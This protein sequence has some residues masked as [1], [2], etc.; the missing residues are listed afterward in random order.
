[1]TARPRQATSATVRAHWDERA[2]SYDREADRIERFLIGDGRDWVCSQ[3][4]GRTLEVAVGT[5]RNLGRY[6]P[7][8]ELVGIDL[9]PGMLAVAR[10][11]ADELGVRVDLREADAQALP[12]D[13]GAFD[14]V[15][16]TL[17]LCS[18]PDLEQTIGELDRVLRPGGRLILLDHVRP[19]A[20]LLRRLLQAVQWAVDRFMPES[21]E[22]FLRRPLPLVEE[23][24]F[25]VERHERL[26]GGFIERFAARKPER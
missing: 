17:S 12:F 19:T 3:A 2:A 24:G 21:G 4:S 5:G 26:K 9:S 11:R 13:D 22:N 7:D 15:V 18:V 6:G 20:P 10:R 16:S 14:T 1:M 8:V 23:R 25:V